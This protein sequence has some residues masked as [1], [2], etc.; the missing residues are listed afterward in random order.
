MK[1]WYFDSLSILQPESGP[2]K[3]VFERL[4]MKIF[5]SKL[6][7]WETFACMKLEKW[8][9]NVCW[10]WIC[11]K[12]MTFLALYADPNHIIFCGYFLHT[13]KNVHFYVK[14]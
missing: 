7:I 9:I 1:S 12:N 6:V 10:I 13:W 5:F 4:E 8:K 11:S 3:E 14:K 2:H